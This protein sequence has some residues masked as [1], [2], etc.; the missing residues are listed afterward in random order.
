MQ[1]V[2]TPLTDPNHPTTIFFLQGGLLPGLCLNAGAIFCCPTEPELEP[3]LKTEPQ[4]E[5]SQA[6]RIAV[7]RRGAELGWAGVGAGARAKA[8]AGAG[9]SADAGVGAERSRAEPEQS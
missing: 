1:N 2:P 4:P 6:G 8:R 7:E 5:P 9:A 3:E